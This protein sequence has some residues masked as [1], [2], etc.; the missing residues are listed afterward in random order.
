MKMYD[1]S[2][3]VREELTLRTLAGT[4]GLCPADALP[5]KLA[6][7]VTTVGRCVVGDGARAA[8][9]LWRDPAGVP[10]EARPAG[11]A[12]R[13]AAAGTPTDSRTEGALGVAGRELLA[14]APA[15]GRPSDW[16]P[17]GVEERDPGADRA[18]PSMAALKG[19]AAAAAPCEPKAPAI[20]WNDMAALSS[21]G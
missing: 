17:V 13:K 21:A 11:V 14:A 19:G 8:G 12:V 9:V 2:C 16:R 15:G 5:M 18:P 4:A 20:V 7:G 3:A 10:K 1:R 6:W